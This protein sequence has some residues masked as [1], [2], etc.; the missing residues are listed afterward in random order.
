MSDAAALL[1]R[2]DAVKSD[3]RQHEK[4]W[5]DCFDHS[6]P[7]RGSGL[8]DS[9]FDLTSAKT[10]RAELLDGTATDACR[11]LAAAMMSGLT[12]ANARWFELFVGG[13]DDEGKE[14]L[15]SSADVMHRE[16]H[17]A[18]F[19]AAAFECQLDSTG[20]GWFALYVD[21]DTETGLTFEQWPLAQVY[22]ASSKA[23]GRVDTIFRAYPMSAEQAVR[24][25]GNAVSGEVLRLAREKPDTA[26][27]FLR[28]ILPRQGAAGQMA[29]NL[30]VR[31]VTIEVKSKLIVRDSGYHETPVV[32]PRWVLIPGSAY[33]VGPMW[34]ALPDVKELNALKRLERQAAELAILPPMKATDD[35][36][37]NLGSVK[38]LQSG[39]LY[40]VN[41]M[42]NIQPITTGA[43]FDLAV[44]DEQRLQAAIRRTLLA[45]QLQPQDGPAMTATE[46]HARVALVRQLLGPIYGRMQA[47]YLSPL[48]ER[49]FG[50]LYRAGWLGPAPD[51]LAGRDFTV[52]Y[53]S[54]L[55]RAQRLE[56]VSAIERFQ[57]NLA[58]VAQFKPEVL[59]LYDEDEGARVVSEAL[60]VPMKVIR[61]RDEVDALR[62]ARQEAQAQAQQ[63]AQMQAMG[64]QMMDAG[65]KQAATA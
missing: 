6:F 32:V 50:L 36:V 24:E 60:G 49:V 25:F 51:T 42:D 15:E 13:A 52:R 20:A 29:R 14:W 9:T 23:G 11:T 4:T 22:Y 40:A 62:E 64:A 53:I 18:A 59:D 34:D 63:Q 2:F 12:P 27:D 17:A 19:D 35:G 61:G 37:L 8:N 1:R 33:A 10:T 7:L 43:R 55:A 39:R 65:I 16:I 31:S 3:R 54:P 28:V 57:G 30:P 21:M 5:R 45:D 46:V 26:V 48:V 44:S 58:A 38:R 56:D 47:E 41:D